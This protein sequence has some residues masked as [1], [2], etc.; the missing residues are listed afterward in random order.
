MDPF[1]WSILLIAA[2]IAVMALELFLPSAGMLG[3]L[4]AI[5]LLSGIVVGFMHDLKTG[6]IVLVLTMIVIPVLLALMVKFWPHTPIGRLIMLGPLSDKDVLPQGGH[7]SELKDLVGQL[8]VAKTKM[9]PSGIVMINGKKYD[10]FSD[11][12]PIEKNQAV[13]V[14]AIRGNR[15]VVTSFGV[16]DTDPENLPARDDDTLSQP[17]DELGL[18]DPM[19]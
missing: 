10:A 8:G 6:T 9:L 17:L 2:G 15:I 1:Y 5:L 19:N 12:M 18:D 16:E 11:G 7:Y 3:V 13:K 4:S 14:L